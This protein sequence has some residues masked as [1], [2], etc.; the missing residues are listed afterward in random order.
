LVYLMVET[1]AE[2]PSHSIQDDPVKMWTNWKENHMA[3]RLVLASM[4]MM[5]C[6]ASGERR[7]VPYGL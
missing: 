4:P 3:R 6:L 7:R 5:I 2:N 1:R